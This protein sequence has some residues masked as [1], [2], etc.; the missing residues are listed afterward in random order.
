MFEPIRDTNAHLK[1]RQELNGLCEKSDCDGPSHKGVVSLPQALPPPEFRMLAENISTARPTGTALYET[2]GVLCSGAVKTGEA[3]D[4]H[5][6]A[7][8]TAGSVP[9]YDM[10][11]K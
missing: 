6:P 9:F 10:D 4:I 1:L 8:M 5:Q 2:V 7:L 11:G 3:G